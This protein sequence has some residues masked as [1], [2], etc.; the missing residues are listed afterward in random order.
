MKR[1]IGRNSFVKHKSDTELVPRY[2]KNSQG[3][4]IKN[5]KEAKERSNI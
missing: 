2:I 3:S 4:T 1:Q 5:Q